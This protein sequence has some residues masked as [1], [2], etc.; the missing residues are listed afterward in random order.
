LRWEGNIPGRTGTFHKMIT[1]H[2]KAVH[3][4]YPIIPDLLAK[5]KKV[6]KGETTYQPVQISGS[7][8][9]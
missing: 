9:I 3:T 4:I 8:G 6:I 1:V 7:M 2:A 5:V